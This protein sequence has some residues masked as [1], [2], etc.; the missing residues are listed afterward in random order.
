MP[1]RTP[2]A[3]LDAEAV[4]TGRAF[5]VGLSLGPPP[6]SRTPD[7]RDGL[8][9]VAANG[10]S[11]IRTGT[12]T[13]SLDRLDEQIASV[14]R[15]HEVARARGLTCWLALGQTPNLPPAPRGK[16]DDERLLTRIVA[17]FRDDPALVAYKGI[18][19]PRNPARGRDYVRPAG[20]IRAYRKLKTLD[21]RHPVVVVHAPRSTAAQLT[22][23]RPACDIAGV[24]VYPV[25]YPPGVHVGRRRDIAVVGD[26][27]TTLRRAA[28]RK[29][30]WMT[31]QVAFSGVIPSKA[32]PATVPR[33]PSLVQER[34]MAYQAIVHGARGLF[35]FGGH[36]QEVMAPED[37]ASGWNWTFWRRVLRPLVSELASRELR[38]ALVAPNPRLGASFTPRNAAIE[39]AFRR[40]ADALFLIAVKTGGAPVLVEFSGLPRTVKGGE[41]LFEYVQ[42]PLPPPITGHQVRRPITV[43]GG[44]FRDWFV[45]H[46]ARVYRFPR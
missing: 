36:L 32:D 9:E 22:P 44:S 11:V 39:F 33:F 6:G 23:Y 26:V 12:A 31:L 41:V 18:D 19:E 20:M 34:F 15:V 27:A 8:E 38:P 2:A 30:F 28:G 42:E 35:F 4:A 24:D 13:W 16:S 1:P 17:A 37:A 45:A 7:G 14:E 5:P 46:D 25:S 10:V 3:A 29:P 43:S 40:T 21:A